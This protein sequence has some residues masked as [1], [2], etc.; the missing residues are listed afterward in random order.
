VYGWVPAHVI[1]MCI[2]GHGGVISGQLPPFAETAWAGEE[3]NVTS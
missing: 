2:D 1:R 3:N